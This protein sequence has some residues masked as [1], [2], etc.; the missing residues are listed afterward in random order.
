VTERIIEANGV[1][2]CTETFGDPADPPVLLI[3]GTGASMLWWEDDFCAAL[4]AGGRFVIR[5]DH[6]DTGR[7]ETYPPGRPPYSGADLVADAA[8]VLDAYGVQRA[9]VVGLSMGGALAQLLAL[10]FADRV[11]SLVLMSTTAVAP[12]DDLPGPTAAYAGAAGAAA[13][14]VDWSDPRSIVEY[15]VAD[16]RAL[17][18]AER[19]FDEAR[20]RAFVVRDVE[21]ARSSASVQNHGLLSG[22]E[23]ARGALD[24]IA[25]PTLVVHGTADPLF[26]L[27]HGRALAGAIPGARLLVLPGAGHG[28]DRADRDRVV[29]AILGHTAGRDATTPP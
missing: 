12:G 29:E 5:Y 25:V 27:E 15:V 10:D 6:R 4:G 13:A 19:P 3:M 20:M 16:A 8:G 2:L 17:A 21:R 11:A 24:A 9:H 28:L 1:R 22:G 23:P 26:P 18:G 14:A 7:S